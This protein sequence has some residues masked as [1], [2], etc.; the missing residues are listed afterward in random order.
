[1]T[2]ELAAYIAATVMLIGMPVFAL[3]EAMP[4]RWLWLCELYVIPYA[5]AVGYMLVYLA[6]V[7]ATLLT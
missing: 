4:D 3:G 1:M 6:I 5:L 2:Y 7:A